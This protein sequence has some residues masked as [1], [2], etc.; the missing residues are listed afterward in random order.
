V[1]EKTTDKSG[2]I[3]IK[4]LSLDSSCD[5]SYEEDDSR[6]PHAMFYESNQPILP[7]K[8]NPTGNKLIW[9]KSGLIAGRVHLFSY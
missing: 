7:H 6:Y 2:V 8:V 5:I 3:E 1:V 4:G 9:K